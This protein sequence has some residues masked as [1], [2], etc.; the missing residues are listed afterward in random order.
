MSKNI[1]YVLKNGQL[2]NFYELPVMKEYA[3]NIDD[4]EYREY[5]G[6]SMGDHI[7]FCGKTKSGKSL[8][9][10]NYLY[11]CQNL[12]KSPFFDKIYIL[13]KKKEALTN[14]IKDSLGKDY[15]EIFY[16]IS[17]FPSVESFEDGSKTNKKKY[18][19]VIDDYVN[20]KAGKTLKK[21]QDYFTFGRNKNVVLLF[22]TQ[23][24]FQTDIFIRKQCA[25]VCLCGISGENDLKRILSD[26]KSRNVDMDVLELMYK[27]TKTSVEKGQP[28]FLKIYTQNCS[29]NERYTMNFTIPLIPKQFKNMIENKPESDNDLNY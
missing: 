11:I 18:L 20:D 25:Y 26:F 7:I 23:S 19:V 28:S 16:D 14:M 9:F 15:V 27:Y 10:L 22:L 6:F 1:K 5:T 13:A 8:S 3:C 29:E 12:L 2:V 4:R 21:I 17:E 24:F